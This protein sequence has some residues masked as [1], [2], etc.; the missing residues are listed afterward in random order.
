MQGVAMKEKEIERMGKLLAERLEP[1]LDDLELCREGKAELKCLVMMAKEYPRKLFSDPSLAMQAHVVL[2]RIE[3]A[4]I[5]DRA[6]IE[7]A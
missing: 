6:R 2:G 3:L 4:G 1:L 5:A 7:T